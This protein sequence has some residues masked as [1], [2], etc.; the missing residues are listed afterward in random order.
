M[1]ASG[2]DCDG[3]GAG[4]SQAVL[5]TEE[6][7]G[8]VGEGGGVGEGGATSRRR[9]VVNEEI[10]WN[11]SPFYIGKYFTKLESSESAQCNTCHNVIKTKQGNT[12]GLDSHLS[13]KHGTQ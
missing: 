8:S 11:I 12:S 3:P 7:G 2:Y 1:S 6:E 13:R 10:N 9:E 5:G 4:P